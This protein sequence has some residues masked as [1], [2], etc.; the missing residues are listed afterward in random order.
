M[1]HPVGSVPEPG[2][3][4]PRLVW[5]SPAPQKASERQ[6]LELDRQEAEDLSQAPH[7]NARHL[8]YP[9]SP[10][11][12]FPVPD[13]KVPWEVSAIQAGW[14]VLGGEGAV[15]PQ[16]GGLARSSPPGPYW[17]EEETT[18]RPHSCRCWSSDLSPS[19]PVGL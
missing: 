6:D 11:L 15:L 7:V 18:T 2:W 10:V 1:R 5:L 13:E 8:F 16:G 17:T 3:L 12:R 4:C 9:N 14:A 19:H